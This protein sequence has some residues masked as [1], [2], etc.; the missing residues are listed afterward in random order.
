[1]GSYRTLM[2][3]GNVLVISAIPTLGLR[4]IFH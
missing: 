4:I 2:W 1:M 3:L